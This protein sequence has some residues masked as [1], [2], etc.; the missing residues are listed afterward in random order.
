MRLPWMCVIACL[1]SLGLSACGSANAHLTSING[2]LNPPRT[3][4]L[5]RQGD[6]LATQ[7]KPL[8]QADVDRAPA[9]SPQRVVLDMWRL[10]QLGAPNVF[11]LYEPLMARTVTLQVALGTFALEQPYMAGTLPEIAQVAPVGN[12]ATVSLLVFSAGGPPSRQSIFLR[13]HGTTWLIAYDTFL[14]SA[15]GQYVQSSASAGG[16]AASAGAQKAGAALSL[17]FHNA[18][19]RTLLPAG[20]SETSTTAARSRP[21]KST[22]TTGSA[23]TTGSSTT[24]GSVKTTGSPTATGSGSASFTTSTSAST[25][26]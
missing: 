26:P 16:A 2:F 21:A 3:T 1:A 11:T 5:V 19:I 18:F 14:D 22:A 12:A 6:I 20:V 17:K 24:T 13:R 23:T 4:P 8:T 10:G 15:L 7:P 25:A 9:G